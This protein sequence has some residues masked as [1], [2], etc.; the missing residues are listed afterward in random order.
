MNQ[1]YT[2]DPE[3]AVKAHTGVHAPNSGWWRP[4]DDPEPF[5]Y[6]QQGDL[7]PALDGHETQWVMV[8]PLAPSQRSNLSG[9]HP[10]F[11]PRSHLEK[12]SN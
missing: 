5:R 12:G 6:I 3:N 10:T 8:Y 1:T 7:M 4:A 9:Q 2:R 11:I